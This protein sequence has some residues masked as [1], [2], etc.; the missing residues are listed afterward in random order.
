M[1]GLMQVR[2]QADGRL[3]A[4]GLQAAPRYAVSVTTHV[5]ACIVQRVH[6]A[7]PLKGSKV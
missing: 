3:V 1:A 7:E 5:H 6:C 2:M 4:A